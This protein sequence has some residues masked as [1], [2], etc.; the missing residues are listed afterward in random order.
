MATPGETG[1]RT[2]MYHALRKITGRG[3]MC[4]F[5]RTVNEKF[6]TAAD[7]IR[8]GLE[9][10]DRCI[11]LCAVSP[12]EARKNLGAHGVP[13]PDPSGSGAF[14][15][16]EM[17]ERHGTPEAMREFL[18]KELDAAHD[19]GYASL[20]VCGAADHRLLKGDP[21][22]V[23]ARTGKVNTFFHENPALGLFQ[24]DI[25]L[26]SPETVYAVVAAYPHIAQNNAVHE[27]RLYG[28]GEPGETT[29]DSRLLLE[30][31]A[32]LDIADHQLREME[33]RYRQVIDLAEDGIL[34]VTPGGSIMEAN[35]KA[36]GI[37]GFESSEMVGRQAE[38]LF[39]ENDLPRLFSALGKAERGVSGEYGG[40]TILAA[41][42]A[43]IPADIIVNALEI[44]GRRI[45]K[46]TVH[47]ASERRRL[48]NAL[49]E[50]EN[51]YRQMFDKNKAVN[52]LIDPGTGQIVDVNE[53][54]AGFYGFTKEDLRK[55][56]I[57]HINTLPPERIKN[58]MKQAVEEK[59]NYFVFAHRISSGELRDVEVY[60][61]PVV[62]GNRTLLH[63]IVHDITERKRAEDLLKESEQRYRDLAEFLPYP[64][65][66]HAGGII[67]Y[68]NKATLNL[69][70]MVGPEDAVG[71]PVLNFVHPDF[72]A[73]VVDR[74]RRMTATGIAVPMIEEKFLLPDGRT[75]DVEVTARPITY[76]GEK[77]LLS[78][79][80][81]V[82]EKKR[83]QREIRESESLHRTVINAT[84]QGFWMVDRDE[85]TLSVNDSLCR[86]LGY[87][88][89]EIIG[90]KASDFVDKDSAGVL[91][92]QT[93]RVPVTE[94][95]SYEVG[96]KAKDGR[97][98][99][100]QIN[101][102][103]L[104]GADGKWAS[105]FAFVTDITERKA[106]EA[107][108]IEA[109]ENAER[110][111]DIK[112]RL[113]AL[114]SQD[115]R[116]PLSTILGFLKL[117]VDD[118]DRPLAPDV[119]R[120][121]TTALDSAWKMSEMVDGLLGASH[122]R[123]GKIAMRGAF[124][125]PFLIAAKA[126]AA[127]SF[128]AERKGIA[129]LNAVDPSLRAYADPDL[130][131]QALFNLLSNAVKFCG[132]S[133]TVTVA[134]EESSRFR[135]TVTDTGP[136]IAPERMER[137]FGYTMDPAIGTA[138][139]KGSGL[140]LPLCMEIMRA[141]GGDIGAAKRPGGGTIIMLDLPV[142]R[143]FLLIV[144]D[145][146][147]GETVRK[148]LAG[149]GILIA[150]ARDCAEALKM[151]PLRRPHLLLVDFSSSAM[152]AFGLSR[153]LKENPEFNR[154]PIIAI[155]GN[156]DGGREV[157]LQIGVKNILRKDALRATFAETV[158]RLL[159]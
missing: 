62:V 12:T 45:C 65:V 57:S 54:A 108:L 96:L 97:R 41:G 144:G 76:K 42:G 28:P 39:G 49:R 35:K 37:F 147:I 40:F 109:K 5:Y 74:V 106:N 25:G 84:S 77:A 58:A 129:V 159:M 152:D 38:H 112:N 85:I 21:A 151:I 121:L 14:L 31:V 67:K 116:G 63:S 1:Q 138:G 118:A 52:L 104:R 122:L 60:S 78:V 91:Y 30:A 115:L 33:K 71:K 83:I 103:T 113:I 107:A 148:T 150:E 132:A 11:F 55:L 51:M 34:F 120:T 56:K 111:T 9:H 47:D 105:S 158:I 155:T 26:L 48:E 64:L 27:N 36:C 140:G 133:D 68:V 145:S 100:A 69:F 88:P 70:S 16:V 93:S 10:G 87:G 123:V 18:E 141:H 136:G 114:V 135:I 149:A 23:L 75:I 3:P 82:T 7:F 22:A 92:E 44:A 66:V 153:R 20:R 53:A 90:K 156:A 89:G 8:I 131:Y 86:M 72:R 117:A 50:S 126:M 2:D 154:I 124:V 81:D 24:Y 139:E 101:A 99:P 128:M 6:S 13:H 146:G 102:T 17:D 32:Q 80:N 61:G 127:A 110:A 46:L 125:S 79:F 43:R 143:P 95:R 19:D 142:V 98:V 59:I 119:K 94:H 29:W 137:L 73:T 130:L 15:I 157:A 4:H 134:A